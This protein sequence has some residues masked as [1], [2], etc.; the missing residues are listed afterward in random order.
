MSLLHQG[1]FLGVIYLSLVWLWDQPGVR[2]D[3]ELLEAVAS[4]VALV[5][6]VTVVENRK[7]RVVDA[8]HLLRAHSHAP[9]PRVM[10]QKDRSPQRLSIWTRLETPQMPRGRFLDD[11]QAPQRPND[12]LSSSRSST[13]TLGPMGSP[14][15]SLRRRWQTQFSLAP[16]PNSRARSWPGESMHTAPLLSSLPLFQQISANSFAR[17]SPAAFFSSRLDAQSR[18]TIR[19][20][21][22]PTHRHRRRPRQRSSSNSR[23][24]SR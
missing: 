3:D 13:F 1:T 16:T 22:D 12:E 18:T 17:S 20:R 7:P 9:Q 24:A 19:L 2:D 14:A 23:K 21:R 8:K 15:P 10:P 5:G 11:W 4:S 6:S